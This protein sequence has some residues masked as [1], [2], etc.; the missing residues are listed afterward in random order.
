MTWRACGTFYK[1]IFSCIA[2]FD[3]HLKNIPISEPCDLIRI[4]I[5]H[6]C[7]PIDF[8]IELKL[9]SISKEMGTPPGILVL[10]YY[11]VMLLVKPVLMTM[12]LISLCV[13]T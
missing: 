3:C 13:N 4:P 9:S 8:S 12:G 10:R 5:L 6:L 11:I 7:K 2:V 1:S